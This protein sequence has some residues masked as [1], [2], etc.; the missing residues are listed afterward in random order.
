MQFFFIGRILCYDIYIGNYVLFPRKVPSHNALYR[1]ESAFSTL[2]PPLSIKTIELHLS[3]GL[4][5]EGIGDFYV[6]RLQHLFP[7]RGGL[8]SLK[9]VLIPEGVSPSDKPKDR[10]GIDIIGKRKP[11]P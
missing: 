7:L 8:I 6:T 3:F 4:W 5:R 1:N 9:V 2:R 11:M 10:V